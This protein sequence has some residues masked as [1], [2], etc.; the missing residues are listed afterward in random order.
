MDGL[1]APPLP[2]AAL[3]AEFA[4]DAGRHDRDGSFPHAN[5]RRLHAEGLLG[6]TAR[7]VD[8][9]GEAGLRRVAGL[10]GT[11]GQGCPATA[12]V[13]AM[14]LIHQKAAARAAGWPAHLR[15]ALGRG[16]VGD[17]ALVNALRVEP[18][19]G[20]PARGGLPA[21]VAS[22]TASGW[23]LDGRKIYSTGAPALAW[24][25]VWARTDD[26]APRTGNFLV[27][28][29]A[30]GVRIVES[31][32][33]LG[34]RASASH[35]VVLDGV[36][37]PADHALELRVPAAWGPPDPVQAAWNALPVAALYTGVAT[38]ARDWFAGFLRGR[39]PGNLGAPLAT[40]PRM[41]EAVGR[42]EALLLANRSLIDRAAEAADAGHPPPASESGIIKA[43]AA[44]NSIAAVQLAV[45]LAGN[46]GLSRAN[47]LERHLRDV[48][49]ARIHTPQADA[50]YGAAGRALLEP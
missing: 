2:D 46:P 15:A 34:L 9:G 48:L 32:D 38:A 49:C 8:G 35:D 22:R 16:A 40:L 5:F 25:L 18:D 29:Q 21:T 31:W 6:L 45:E 28:A 39:V 47:P 24:M 23:R 36:E 42:M 20:T 33:Q 44:E 10:V 14:Q 19:L 43:L 3:A 11:I 17:G 7:A 37:I 41:Q 50:A 1:Y 12:L 4:R 30:P 27:P 26:A 13:L